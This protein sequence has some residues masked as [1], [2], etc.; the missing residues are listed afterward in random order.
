M[1]RRTWLKMAMVA[2]CTGP[3]SRW[4]RAQGGGGH[5]RGLGF[6]APPDSAYRAIQVGDRKRTYLL[7]EPAAPAPAGGRPLILILHGGGGQGRSMWSFAGMNPI[8]DREGAIVV[9]PDGEGHFWNVGQLAAPF[10]ADDVAFFGALLHAIPETYNINP[11]R[12]YAAGISNGGMM[13]QRL[14]CELTR[15]FA[16]VASISGTLPAALGES[17]RPDGPLS[18]MVMHGSA[19]PLVPF[20]GGRV[21]GSRGAVV[22]APDTVRFWVAHNGCSIVPVTTDLPHL[23]PDDVTSTR[24]QLY[25][26]GQDGSQ[27]AFYTIS[28]GGHTWPGKPQYLPADMIGPVSRDFDASEAIWRFFD[29]TRNRMRGA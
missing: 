29:G 12:V 1:R 11:R 14:A 5:G 27:V 18:V 10:R 21:V 17:A 28:N 24:L 26:G 23:S 3:I 19:D 20:N 4:A 13:V 16:A 6:E 8:A 25:S 22:S 7:Y 2:A 9:Y 15:Q